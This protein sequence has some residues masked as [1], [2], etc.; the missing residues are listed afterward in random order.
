MSDF[1]R[2]DICSWGQFNDAIREMA[3]SEPSEGLPS[4]KPSEGRPVWLYRGQPN[5]DPLKTTIERALDSWDIP[6]KQH[7]TSIEFQTIRE[8]RRRLTQPEYDRVQ[9]DTLHCLALMR[10]HYAPTR[11][12]DCTY[13]PFVAAAFAMEN[14]IFPRQRRTPVV[15]CFNAKWCEEAAKEKLPLCQ[16][17]LIEQRNDD[18][19]RTDKTFLDLFQLKT[20]LATSAPKWKF[21][22]SKNP[23]HLNERLTA[24]QGAFL[25]PADLSSS[26]EDNLKAMRDRDSKDNLRKLCLELSEEEARKF[27]RNLKDMNISFAAL[28]PGLDGFA[29]SIN[30]QI[31]HYHELAQQQAGLGVPAQS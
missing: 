12:L 18:N 15:W 20:S 5:D 3:S 17:T 25:C 2:Q 7:A 14:G 9:K 4:S 23:L 24:Q 28:F 11:L 13:S 21:V 26:F 10:H 31:N 8:F 6:L 29:K 19:L 27:A 1:Y 22:K 16:R 30:Q